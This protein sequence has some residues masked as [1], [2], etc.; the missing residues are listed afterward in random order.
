MLQRSLLVRSDS[1][2]KNYFALRTPLFRQPSFESVVAQYNGK[3]LKTVL[4]E[5]QK[6]TKSI[7][8]HHLH[9]QAK[10]SEAL[11]T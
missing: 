1:L 5:L 10:N 8:D 9:E 11:L 4:K 2:D 6:V 3:S 7:A